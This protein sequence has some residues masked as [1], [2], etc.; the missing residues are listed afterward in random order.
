MIDTAAVLFRFLV[1]Y[2]KVTLVKAENKIKKLME[3]IL[4][5]H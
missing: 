3:Q 4:T 1:N 5:F 2:V